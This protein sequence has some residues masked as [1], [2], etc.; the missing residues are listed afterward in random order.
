MSTEFNRV[1]AGPGRLLGAL[2][3]AC[4]AV[5]LVVALVAAALASESFAAAGAAPGG[6]GLQ[7]ALT[8]GFIVLV[9]IA[10]TA[11]TC[12]LGVVFGLSGV[13]LARNHPHGKVFL[14]AL[15]LAAN[16]LPLLGASLFF[17][18]LLIH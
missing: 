10:V 2:S 16:G 4:F 17:L 15:G 8:G 7:F 13:V 14:P 3:L 18:Y 5:T 12:L 11:G 9:S 1:R 6:S